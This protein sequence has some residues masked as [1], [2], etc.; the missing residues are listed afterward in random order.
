MTQQD[1]SKRWNKS[2]GTISTWRSKR[3][4]PA[5]DAVDPLSWSEETVEA[6]EKAGYVQNPEQWRLDLLVVTGQRMMEM[7]AMN[8]PKEVKSFCTLLAQLIADTRISMTDRIDITEISLLVLHA[9]S[10]RPGDKTPVDPVDVDF[11]Y[12]LLQL[13]E[14]VVKGGRV[15]VLKRFAI[16]LRVG[17]RG[18]GEKIAASN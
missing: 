3:W 17:W 1:L 14:A 15:D 4:M 13:F 7:A 2:Q 6:Y 16:G 8:V 10:R 5:P 12:I 9:T 18:K 11:F